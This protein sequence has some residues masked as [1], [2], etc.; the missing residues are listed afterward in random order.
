MLGRSCYIGYVLK[1]ESNLSLYD[2]YTIFIYLYYCACENPLMFLHNTRLTRH[3]VNFFSSFSAFSSENSEHAEQYTY[4][5][6]A[7]YTEVNKKSSTES[8][9]SENVGGQAIIEGIIMRYKGMIGFAVR[10]PRGEIL[11]EAKTWQKITKSPL[12]EKPFFR[13][14]PILAE[15]IINGI[16]ALNRS[17]ILSEEEDEPLTAKQLLFTLIISIVLAL[18]L[19]VVLPHLLTAGMQ[20]LNLSGEVQ[21]FSFQVWDGVFKLLVFFLYLVLISQLSD[22]RRVFQYHGAEHKVIAAYEEVREGDVIDIALV[23]KQS[24]LHARC[25]TTFLLFVL[26]VA[27]LLHTVVLPPLLMLFDFQSTFLMHAVTLIIKI[28]LMIPVAS[29][30]YELIRYTARSDSKW[31]SL[32]KTPGLFL[33]KL[34]TKE[35]DDSQLEVA[36]VALKVALGSSSKNRID[37]PEYKAAP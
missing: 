25:G 5:E 32:L 7:S 20:Y 12:F 18:G 14:F 6:H 4:S 34:T 31:V 17:A 9:M 11:A 2:L 13:G 30:A 27:I 24:R 35:P 29:A 36:L 23:R 1:T 10:S 33:Q 22:I 21:S 15:T 19:F 37:V 16:K 28:L 8:C 26:T 3:L